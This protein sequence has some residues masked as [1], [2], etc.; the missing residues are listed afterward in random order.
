MPWKSERGVIR[1]VRKHLRPL[2][3]TLLTQRACNRRL[4]RLRGA[5]ILIQ[6]AVAEELAHAN[7]YNVM[8]GFPLPVAHGARSFNP[9]WVADIA[10]IGIGGNDRYCSGVRMMM[11][12]NQQGVATGWALAAGNVQERWVAELLFRTRAWVPGVQGPLDAQPQQPKMTPP[13]AWMAVL[14]R[15]GVVSH[16]PILSDCG[17]RGED[18]LTHWPATSAAHVCPLPKA[19]PGAQRR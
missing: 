4:Q 5:F 8:D 16:K 13:A 19:A 7:D 18:W 9:G 14:P 3:P 11:V 15:C 17:F 2:F 1:Y 10:R 12:I 6:D